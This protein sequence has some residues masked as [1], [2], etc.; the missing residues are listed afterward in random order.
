VDASEIERDIR[1]IDQKY[2]EIRRKA[3]ELTKIAN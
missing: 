1:E 3:Q 2:C